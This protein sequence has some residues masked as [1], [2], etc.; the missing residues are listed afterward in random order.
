[1]GRCLGV[2]RGEGGNVIMC[3]QFSVLMGWVHYLE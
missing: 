2:A 1:M 3:I